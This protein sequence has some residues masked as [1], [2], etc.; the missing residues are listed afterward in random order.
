M[1]VLRGDG[2]PTAV[3]WAISVSHW[4]ISYDANPERGGVLRIDYNMRSLVDYKVVCMGDEITAELSCLLCKG[5]AFGIWH[6][7]LLHIRVVVVYSGGFLS[8]G[9]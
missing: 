5:G 1:G 4:G 8:R 3:A 7:L 2:V 9:S 6:R